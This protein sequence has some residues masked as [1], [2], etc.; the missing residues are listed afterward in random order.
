[1]TSMVVQMV[2]RSCS[3]TTRRR[4]SPDD[5]PI[6]GRE[7]R[8][9][10]VNHGEEPLEALVLAAT[11]GTAGV[12]AQLVMGSGTTGVVAGG[13]APVGLQAAQWFAAHVQRRRAAMTGRTLEAPGMTG[14]CRPRRG[15]ETGHHSAFGTHLGERRD[16]HQHG[17]SGRG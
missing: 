11:A 10:R 1:M 5:S 9:D 7:R 12:L 4:R 17:R 13:L 14:M 15:T 2:V 8:L 16:D 3:G 6:A